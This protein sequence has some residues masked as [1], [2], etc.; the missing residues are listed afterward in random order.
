M[1][2]VESSRNLSNAAR[3]KRASTGAG[4]AG[5]SYIDQ[6]WRGARTERVST[7]AR[8]EIREGGNDCVLF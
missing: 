5:G 2:R 6:A 8:W 4:L 7:A 3:R 1:R